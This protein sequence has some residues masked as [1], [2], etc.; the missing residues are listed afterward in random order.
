[1]PV[2]AGPRGVAVNPAGTFVYVANS[3][4][5]TISVIDTVTNTVVATVP[6]GAGP[7]GVAVNP[8]GTFAYVANRFSNN[9]SVIDTARNTVVATV[10]VGRAPIAFGQFIGGRTSGE[11]QTNPRREGQ[12]DLPW[13]PK[14]YDHVPGSTIGQLGCAMTA[15]S[16]ALNFVGVKNNPLTLN[17]FMTSFDSDYS[18]SGSVN[19]GPATI[20]AS[21][22]NNPASPFPK[23]KQMRFDTLGGAKYSRNNSILNPT[24]AFKQVNDALCAADPHPVIVGVRGIRGC[25]STGG[26]PSPDK[27]GH[28]VLITGKQV[29]ANGIPHYSII[30]PGCQ[31]NTSLDVFNNEFVT[32]GVVKDPPGDISELDI[33]VDGSADLLVV[34]PAGNVTGHDVNL[35][36]I[37]Q[38]IAGSSYISDGLNDDVTGE[39]GTDITHQ[40]PIF[41][42]SV[43]TFRINVNGTK[44][45][46]Y[47][48][49]VRAFSQ[50][51]RAQPFIVLKG[52]GAPG[53]TTQYQV[54]F[55]SAPGSVSSA[56]V[57]ATFEGTLSDIT[58][59]LQLGLIDNSGV[60]NSLS[61]KI[62][63]AQKATGS[64]RTNILNAFKN[65]VNAQAGK[66]VT[67]VAVEVFLQ[68]ATSLISQN[69]S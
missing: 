3:F 5:N 68:D 39:P 11:C 65:E 40:V 22:P 46:S 28:F 32:R 15:L 25:A 17:N 26:L 34:D 51:G 9:V 64:T 4:S 16:M 66:H 33:A 31:T 6:V 7:D 35:G 45:A 24:G 23:P 12:A 41:Q 50:D 54:Q 36:T 55:V 58:N 67:G 29:D 42:P 47:T 18:G 69:G 60:A 2:G 14:P 49:S 38:S 10:P 56:N 21:N 52:I 27:P 30:D 37:S 59:S 53:S 13:G 44:L 8:A 48:L 1:M 43:G 19:W 63:A 20:D 61:Q 57:F 62:G